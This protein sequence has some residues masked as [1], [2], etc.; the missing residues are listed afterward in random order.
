MVV[1]HCILNHIWVVS[2]N[3][4]QLV[5]E[6]ATSFSLTPF[7]E[8]YELKKLYFS[9]NQSCDVEWQCGSQSGNC[10]DQSVVLYKKRGFEEIDRSFASLTPRLWWDTM[11]SNRRKFG[12]SEYVWWCLIRLA[13]WGIRPSRYLLPH[14]DKVVSLKKAGNYRLSVVE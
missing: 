3:V 14:L 7:P 11:W 13:L 10:Y 5:A 2:I 8:T 4:Y 9:R 6:K 12:I 1:W